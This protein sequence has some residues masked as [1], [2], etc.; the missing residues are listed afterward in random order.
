MQDRTGAGAVALERSIGGTSTADELLSLMD[1]RPE[2]WKQAACRRQPLEVFFPPD[3]RSSRAAKAICATCV[4][5]TQCL[6]YAMGADPP[7]KGI[8]GGTTEQERRSMRFVA[9]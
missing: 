7:L 8:F 2:W 9:V 3:A 5:R 6:D 4:V 1:M